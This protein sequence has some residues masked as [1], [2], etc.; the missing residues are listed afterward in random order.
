VVERTLIDNINIPGVIEEKTEDKTEG[1]Q[2]E[3]EQEEEEKEEEEE[4]NKHRMT[5]KATRGQP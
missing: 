2:V 4:E 1:E 3:E 5:S